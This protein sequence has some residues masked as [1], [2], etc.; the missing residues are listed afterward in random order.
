MARHVQFLFGQFVPQCRHRVNKHFDDYYVLQ[1]MDGG[2]VDFSVDDRDYH[3]QGRWFFSSYPGPRIRFH[4][5]A[6]GKSWVHR[7]LA[8]RGAAVKQWIKAG[9]FPIAPQ[10]PSPAIDYADRFDALLEL[11]RRTDKWGLFRAG[12]LLE[13]IL[14]E[15]AEARAKPATIP[16]WL[17]TGLAKLNA[18]GAE[19]DYDDLANEAGMPARTFRRR[20]TAALGASPREYAIGCRIGHA[21]HMLGATDLSIKSI[22]E[23]LGYRDVFFFS[24]Q[25]ARV[26]GM[27]PAAYRRTKEA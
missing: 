15:L 10:Q 7:Y 5:G 6:A 26:T 20:F 4:T 22:A 17:E 1:F 11:S 23:Q 12:L 3:L 25:F 8:F 9:L 16:A 14:T 27:A 18:L 24:R 21:K 2:A 19:I 13:T